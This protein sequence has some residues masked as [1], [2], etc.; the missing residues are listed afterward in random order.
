M[1]R[2]IIYTLVATTLALLAIACG[3]GA[4]TTESKK[5][6]VR[7][8][9]NKTSNTITWDTLTV[10]NSQPLDAKNIKA[11]C[12]IEFNFIVPIDYSDAEVLSKIQQQLN[13]LVMGDNAN[14]SKL[15][16]NDAM[17]SYAAAYVASYLKESK[18]QVALW[19]KVNGNA[20]YTYFSYDKRI[21]TKVLYNEANVISYQITETEVKGDETSTILVRNVLFNLQTGD[22]MTQGDIF[23]ADMNEELNK[24]LITQLLKDNEVETVEE[25]QG[26][27][28]W[29]IADLEVSDN[30]YV[31]KDGIT[32]TFSPAEY[33][34]AKLGILNIHVN[35]DY[36][37]EILKDNS[38]ISILVHDLD[39]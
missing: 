21:D 37:L 11:S 6:E 30:F 23:K 1:R 2:I 20:A 38:P 18:S 9:R 15:S 36:M 35:Y 22:V 34:D 3:G 27:G 29:G 5:E 39:E 10:K 12:S 25:L 16:T 13:V 28:Y 7:V 24:V 14:L 8:R 19:R 31:D 17:R 33:S 26:L 4:T 32:F